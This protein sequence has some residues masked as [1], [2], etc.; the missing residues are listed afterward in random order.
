MS[1]KS[2]L[3]PTRTKNYQKHL[4]IDQ[5]LRD[6]NNTL[7]PIEREY[8]ADFITPRHPTLFIIGAPRSGTTLLSQ[9]LI[10]S[11]ELAYINN[12]TAR[13]WMAP[14]IGALLASDMQDHDRPPAVGFESDLGA[15]P[16]YEGPHEFGYFWRRWFEY[17]DTHQLSAAQINN[18]DVSFFTQEI[19]AVESVFD[20]PLLFKNVPA[21][22]L[23]VGFLAKA[24]PGA[25][26][27]HCRRDPVYT[28]QSLL[29]SRLKYYGNKETWFSIK[30]KEY[31]RLIQKSYSQQIAGQIFYTVQRISQSLASIDPSRH[32]TIEYDSLCE[33]PEEQLERVAVLL[34]GVGHPLFSRNAPLPKLFSTNSK[35]VADDEF[36]R[37]QQACRQFFHD[38]GEG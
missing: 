20:R 10:T 24:L 1:D 17:G 29:L 19:A 33:K 30:P 23:Q 21:L 31:H 15:T 25:I 37:L 9:L 11:F 3:M 28:A 4:H 32:L 12:L 2:D 13:Y 7:A 6:M 35:K 38:K 27:I 14:Y 18:I 36:Q 8:V 22:S 26:F 5:V 34:A 16:E